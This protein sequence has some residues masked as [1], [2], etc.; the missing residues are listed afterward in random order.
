M[1][2]SSMIAI[3][4]ALVY[5]ASFV[6]AGSIEETLSN[7]LSIARNLK[8]W[9]SKKN[10]STKQTNNW[11]IS[12]K[13]KSRGD[14]RPSGKGKGKGSRNDGHHHHHIVWVDCGPDDDWYPGGPDDWQPNGPSKGSYSRLLKKGK[15]KSSKSYKKN[16]SHRK[17]KG[18]YDLDWYPSGPSK[19]KGKGKGSHHRHVSHRCKPTETPTYSPWTNSPTHSPLISSPTLIHSPTDMPHVYFGDDGSISCFPEDESYHSGYKY[20]G[21]VDKKVVHFQYSLE[22]TPNSDEE[23][24]AKKVEMEIAKLLFSENILDCAKVH[25][26]KRRVQD[27]N[28]NINDAVR[29]LDVIGIDPEPWDT[30]TVKDNH[31]DVNCCNENCHYVESGMTVI[32]DASGT[33]Y[34]DEQICNIVDLIKDY[35]SNYQPG[36][37]EGVESVALNEDAIGAEGVYCGDIQP[38]QTIPISRIEGTESVDQGG[39][40]ALWS[41]VF[42]GT[43]LAFV[44]LFISRRRR[45]AQLREMQ[46]RCID[47]LEDD[48]NMDDLNL[49]DSGVEPPKGGLTAVDVHVCHSQSCTS[50]QDNSNHIQF[51]PTNSPSWLNEKDA[52]PTIDEDLPFEEDSPFLKNHSFEETEWNNT[53]RNVQ[54]NEI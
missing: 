23:E 4:M 21:P 38:E 40:N 48:L 12:G 39:L 53:N 19:G 8:K 20:D 17:G 51:I 54:Q 42:V 35:T 50:C 31:C 43:F 28:A 2:I 41:C 11:Y 34:S 14:W 29:K 7:N 32:T 49:D 46:N 1:H 36:D 52:T 37:I 47:G 22:T 33:S 44:G 18:W 24:M 26:A 9:K 45:E 13:G 5:S 15:R 3:C 6:V 27:A 16:K 30:V 10:K 25:G